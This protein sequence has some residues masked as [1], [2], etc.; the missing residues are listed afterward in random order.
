MNNRLPY[1]KSL[2][3]STRD[4]LKRRSVHYL[5]FLF[6]CTALVFSSL[7]AR[8]SSAQA[9]RPP[10]QSA[11]SKNAHAGGQRPLANLSLV[12]TVAQDGL[13][14]MNTTGDTLNGRNIC[15]S[16]PSPGCDF[17]EHNNIVRTNDEIMYT[18]QYSVNAGDEPD[19]TVTAAAPFG[20]V[21]KSV[22][23]AFCLMPGSSVNS[24]DGVNTQS[25][26]TCRRG[27]RAGGLTEGLTFA[28]TILGTVLNDTIINA[29]GVV[30]GGAGSP[31]SPAFAGAPNVTV[32]AA[33]RYNLR[34]NFFSYSG[35]DATGYT[36]DYTATIEIL[37]D[38]SP[39]DL[40]PRYGSSVLPTSL[41]FKDTVSAVSPKAQWVSCTQVT[42][43][44]NPAPGIVCDQSG[45]AGTPITANI[46]NL[47]TSLNQYTGPQSSFGI[48]AFRIRVFISA[49]EITAGG[50]MI[51]DT[52]THF[53]P[54]SPSPAN[55][56][57]FNPLGEN[58]NDNG[59]SIPVNDPP[60]P[61]VGNG[62]FRKN[63]VR[64][65]ND[66]TAL[67]FDT[68]VAPNETFAAQVFFENNNTQAPL[69]NVV[70]CDVMDN[71]KYEVIET[72]FGSGTVHQPSG[73]T[74]TAVEFAV[75]YVNPA[76]WL[77]TGNGGNPTG[78][79]T[80]CDHAGIT[81][82]QDL[83]QLP[84]GLGGIS[85]IT[86][87]RVRYNQLLNNASGSVRVRVKARDLDPANQPIPAGTALPNFG[88][89][90][91]DTLNQAFID[92]TFYQSVYPSDPTGTTLFGARV[93]LARAI[94]RITKE[95]E[96]NNM[97]GSI[98]TA[99]PVGIGFVL[100]PT[101]ETL[102]PANPVP[103][104]VTD[105]LPPGL[106]YV[107]GSSS[108]PSQPV[109][110]A[111]TGMGVPYADCDVIGQEIL[112]WTLNPNPTPNMPI[113]PITFRA[114]A[115]LTVLNNQTMTNV[116]IVA[117]PA[118]PEIESLRRATRNVVG[119]APS[120]F[121]IF[122]QTSTPQIDVNGNFSYM[123]TYRNASVQMD[124]TGMDFID[125]L[126]FFGDT[127][128]PFGTGTHTRTPNSVF[129]GTRP[130]MPLAG[131]MGA[132]WYFTDHTPASAINI[133]P[134]DSSNL[135]PGVGAS[136]W[137][138]GTVSGPTSG[139]T[140]PITAVRM[141]DNTPMPH[142][143]AIR[144]FTL[145]FSSNGNQA[146]DVY[147]N[148]SGGSVNELVLPVSSVNVPVTVR[149]GKISGLVWYDTDADGIRDT[150][151]IGRVGSSLVT[152]TGPPSGTQTT[153]PPG[154]YIFN[155]LPGGSYT[156]K[157]TKPV[158]YRI[159]PANRG[160]SD[161]E[162]SDGD[163]TTLIAAVPDLGVAAATV[164]QGFYQLNLRGTV[165]N[166]ANCDGIQGVNEG[167]ITSPIFDLELLDDQGNVV[168]KTQTTGGDYVFVNLPA[169][170]YKVRM[171]TNGIPVSGVFFPNPNDNVD[172]D[173]NGM[174]ETPN[175][176]ISNTIS[177]APG[178][179]P[180]I[181][182]S[183]GTT[184]NKTLD[185]GLC[186]TPTAAAV[187]VGGRVMTADGRGIGKALVTMTGTGGTV[188][189][190]LT[191]PF[192]Y[193]RFDNVAA[194]TT[195]LISVSSKS[196]TFEVGTRVISV[197]DELMDVNFIAME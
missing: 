70:L 114:V 189:R 75:G 154:T 35:S 138:L 118:D 34:K 71:T 33:P 16:N 176:L 72:S 150:E 36:I 146:N 58:P 112:T 104:T 77:P 177:L 54:V 151:E 100:K 155:G 17:S 96:N 28:A 43:F 63:F 57:N 168:R 174:Q 134:K 117:S 190:A 95:T 10:A 127:T 25:V 188:Y 60:P 15:P 89:W 90:K 136:I 169:G 53:N 80:E 192:G 130:L 38:S 185:F 148:N 147:T 173:N 13:A 39:A 9:D 1:A 86:K 68:F 37:D 27:P 93:N 161:A 172:R 191:N 144:S 101:I 73:Q 158:N 94:V 55:Q 88:I 129:S 69:N 82:Y 19:L 98:E 133:N 162:D 79:R 142:S 74:P 163:E 7:S 64:E 56:P 195:V 140:G 5:G 156:V 175:T 21:W 84:G 111:C 123:V 29:S 87:F 50:N 167:P 48:G 99:S 107:G 165:W 67:G 180:E 145:S 32:S 128:L 4:S 124:F 119:A 157:F 11:G 62:L 97:S 171:T 81:W 197:S 46:T 106:H 131:P 184:L 76:T 78:I 110:T 45:G 109:Q 164:D 14:L 3:N 22:L 92:N 115:D 18:Y 31:S 85:A 159:S 83:T 47:N 186:L 20:S 194:G 12:I 102:G 132:T 187:A 91:S 61:P 105:I 160:G 178:T 181:N 139:C 2:L 66:P 141:R 40:D 24:G 137:C 122:K 103:V 125:I 23:P 59:Q 121:L 26:I 170:D 182:H 44:G 51:I 152:L 116:A 52:L 149:D 183:N 193:Y 41:T 166:D 30:S 65:Y 179:E 108:I 143:N 49:A 196:H 6:L 8:Q 120:T 135:N 113:T 126:P 153:G 42:G